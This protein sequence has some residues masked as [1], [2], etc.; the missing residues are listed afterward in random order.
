VEQALQERLIKLQQEADFAV[1][2]QSM[3][4]KAEAAKKQL[5]AVAEI[6]KEV[7]PAELGDTAT[8]TQELAKQNIEIQANQQRSTKAAQDSIDE[9]REQT[10]KAVNMSAV[11][12]VRAAEKNVM[13]A[14][15]AVYTQGGSMINQAELLGNESAGAAN[16]S[17]EAAKNSVLWTKT[18]PTKEAALAVA[19]AQASE[20]MSIH[21]IQEDENAQ[22]MAKLAGNMAI[23]TIRLA[24]EAEKYTEEGQAYTIK[25]VHQAAQNAMQLTNIK[26]MINKANTDA[27]TALGA[28]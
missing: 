10:E 12:E 14:V 21:L 8:L 2:K 11:Y 23:D 28:R 27:L 17:L 20:V 25:A 19:K 4:M 26:T 15:M 18:L 7:P 5:D 9:L 13:N 6:E 16:F 1:K 22:R 3:L 24:E